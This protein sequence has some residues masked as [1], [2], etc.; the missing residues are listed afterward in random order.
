MLKKRP[1]NDEIKARGMKKLKSF[2][3][4]KNN[5]CS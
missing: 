3:S 2:S 5:I 4:Q 1:S